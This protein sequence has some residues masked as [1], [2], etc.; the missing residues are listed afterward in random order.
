MVQMRSTYPHSPSDEGT[1]AKL[2][3]P[4][5]M[6]TH[7]RNRV[8]RKLPWLASFVVLCAIAASAWHLFRQPD[9]PSAPR[10]LTDY[11]TPEGLFLSDHDCFAAWPDYQDWIAHLQSTMSRWNPRRYLLGKRYPRTKFDAVRSNLVCRTI[12]Y[13]SDGYTVS[14]WLLMPR[15]ALGKQSPVLVFNRGGNGAFGAITFARAVYGLSD[16]AEKGFVVVASQYRGADRDQDPERFGSDEFGGADVRDVTRLVELIRRHPQANPERTF[17]FGASRGAMM[18]FLAMKA[19]LKVD[20]IAVMGGVADL[21][22]DLEADPRMEE[23]YRARIPGYVE[24]RSAAPESRSVVEWVDELP[25]DLPV[26]ILHGELDE[27]VQVEQARLLADA[28]RPR[29]MP[30]KLVIY[31]GDDHHLS[32]NRRAV[33]DEVTE[34][35]LSAPDI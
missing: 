31:Q 17:M 5:L 19:G 10:H 21:K 15:A 32:R 29:H 23:V 12:T 24:N 1:I 6:L 11:T 9:T 28:L 20:A 8:M 13:E 22:R 7:A 18:T 14:G 16:Y 26:L 34:W 2:H 30:V 33:V 35:F 3:P 25:R 27:R 4:P